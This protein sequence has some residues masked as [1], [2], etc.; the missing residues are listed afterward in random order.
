MT[1]NIELEFM[2]D[3][4]LMPINR[5][6]ETNTGVEMTR[7]KRGERRGKGSTNSHGQQEEKKVR[8][9]SNDEKH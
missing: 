1:R 9:R 5:E 3:L 2:I 6:K 8:L 4:I 7:K